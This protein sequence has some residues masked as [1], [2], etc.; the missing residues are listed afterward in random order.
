MRIVIFYLFIPLLLLTGG[1]RRSAEAEPTPPAPP[2]QGGERGGLQ[3]RYI[4]VLLLDQIGACQ[5]S[6][7]GVFDVIDPQ[8]KVRLLRAAKIRDLTVRFGEGGIELVQLG[9]KFDVLAIDLVPVDGEMAVLMP[10]GIRSYKGQV[11]LLRS[12][13]GGMLINIVDM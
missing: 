2:Y 7:P 5:L 4:R 1:C 9:R 10:K 3:N 11:R 13:D 12:A 8:K 6:T